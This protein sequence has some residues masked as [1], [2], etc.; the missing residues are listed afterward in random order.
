MFA[1]VFE[2]LP[3]PAGYQRYL[4]TAAALRPRLDEIPG[5]IS[6]ERFRCSTHPGWI[7]S[8]SF[9]ETEAAL[10]QWRG[11][12]EHHAAQ[13]AGRTAIFDDYRIRVVRMLRQDEAVPAGTPLLVLQEYPVA[14]E[15]PR[16][17]RFASLVSPDKDIDL[18]DADPAFA[19]Q[20][21]QETPASRI[22]RGTVMRDYGLF[23][24]QQAPQHFPAV[25][26]EH[27]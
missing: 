21:V 1:V 22:W 13:S 6:I 12:G 2:V 17:K 11:H 5:F 24:R 3:S 10:V 25:T 7:L 27:Q 16:S 26:R 19:P 9:W 23:D 20:S 8:L 14:G 18:W 15:K 4:D